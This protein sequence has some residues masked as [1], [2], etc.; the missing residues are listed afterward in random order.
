[1]E[2][3]GAGAVL[4]VRSVMARVMPVLGDEGASLFGDLDG[5]NRPLR[6]L[7][8]PAH[9]DRYQDI[10]GFR[11][12]FEKFKR[13]FS[14]SAPWNAKGHLFVVT[15]DSGYGKTSLRQ[16]CAHWLREECGQA[17]CEVV[18]VDLSDEDWMD[19]ASDVKLS[20]TRS[21]ILD[22]LR[23][24]LGPDE[25][26]N[27]KSIDDVMISFRTLGTALRTRG[28]A[29][30]KPHPIVL[31]VLLP[32]YP[33]LQEI[34]RYYGLAREGII[35]LAEIYDPR[36]AEDVTGKFAQ[37]NMPFNKDSVEAHVLKLDVLKPGDDILVTDWLQSD[38]EN[39]PNFANLEV[40]EALSILVDRQKVSM[41][42]F[43]KMVTSALRYA[44]EEQKCE[45]TVAH[46]MAFYATSMYE[47]K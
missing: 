5:Y 7:R 27:I 36:L 1:M 2:A 47:S 17:G 19:A 38:V 21:C 46:I 43:M 28:L 34:E 18:V 3:V 15:G 10:D 8:T 39:C 16:R 6:P 35:F 22:E 25:I 42:G 29:Q 12:Q 44:I 32:G 41:A 33:M 11:D 9:G 40:K 26:E 37:R 4:L 30:G 20:R 14:G 45:V 24:H 23:G 31:V 13:I